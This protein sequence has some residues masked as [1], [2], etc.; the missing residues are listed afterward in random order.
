MSEQH[1][2]EKDIRKVRVQI[3][4]RWKLIDKAIMDY[5]K[6]WLN[7]GLKK[8]RKKWMNYDEAKVGY[9]RSLQ[10]VVQLFPAEELER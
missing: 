8:E 9:F 5:G 2:S 4:D 6:L 3:S 10:S 1:R 7:T